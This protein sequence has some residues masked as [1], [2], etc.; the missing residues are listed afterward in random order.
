MS[1][2]TNRINFV[3]GLWIQPHDTLY[4]LGCYDNIIMRNCV[5]YSYIA[6]ALMIV[7]KHNVVYIFSINTT[8]QDGILQPKKMAE[9]SCYSPKVFADITVNG[10]RYTI[11]YN[12]QVTYYR[13]RYNPHPKTN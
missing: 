7:K 6:N 8:K 1:D 9:F 2:K 4:D 12:C 10:Y 5:N 11:D 13:E 3:N